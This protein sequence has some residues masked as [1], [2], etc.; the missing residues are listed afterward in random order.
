MDLNPRQVQRAERAEADPEKRRWKGDFEDLLAATAA[1]FAR[2]PHLDGLGLSKLRGELTASFGASRN[3]F[4]GVYEREHEGVFDWPDDLILELYERWWAPRSQKI[5]LDNAADYENHFRGRSPLLPIREVLRQA[6]TSDIHDYVSPTA[7]DGLSLSQERLY[8]LA[9]ALADRPIHQDFTYADMLRPVSEIT[10]AK[11]RTAYQSLVGQLGRRPVAHPDDFGPLQRQINALLEG[12]VVHRRIGLEIN[13]DELVDA[14]MAL[15]LAGTQDERGPI[16]LDAALRGGPFPGPHIERDGRR[17][18]DED[19]SYQ[20]AIDAI[21]AAA[22]DGHPKCIDMVSMHGHADRKVRPLTAGGE[23]LKK[24]VF[25]RIDEGWQVR[26]VVSANHLSR[27]ENLR[28]EME[29]LESDGPA[30]NL[31]I[32]AN[33]TP[34]VPL[35]APIIIGEHRALLGLEHRSTSGVSHSIIADDTA[36]VDLARAYFDQLWQAPDAVTVR[37]ATGLRQEG[38]TQIHQRLHAQPF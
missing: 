22:K 20:A 37:T 36:T 16:D 8:W 31:W 27:L 10:Q 38:F 3:V 30:R 24:E 2:A 32:K 6:L 4:K 34:S 28:L 26:R 14:V 25:R 7:E 13:E 33:S 21:N 15:A 29:T 17:L 35:I 23:A 5:A 12:Y 1:W 19:D 11:Y 18:L 9:V